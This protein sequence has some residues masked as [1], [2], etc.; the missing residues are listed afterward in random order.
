MHDVFVG[1]IVGLIGAIHP[2]RR[3]DRILRAVG[4]ET[5]R[6]DQRSHQVVGAVNAGLGRKTPTVFALHRLVD[7]V[8]EHDAVE[9]DF[10][11]PLGEVCVEFAGVE[12]LARH[13]ADPGEFGELWGRLRR[14]ADYP[15]STNIAA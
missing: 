4:A 8:L 5:N 2:R 1:A 9:T 14:P 11:N 3:I 7:F 6:R 13:D 12:V 15:S 10:R